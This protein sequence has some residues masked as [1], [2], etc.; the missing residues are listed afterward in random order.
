MTH[1]R[2]SLFQLKLDR[3]PARV[4]LER[5][6]SRSFASLEDDTMGRREESRAEPQCKLLAAL[7]NR[8]EGLAPPVKT[9]IIQIKPGRRDNLQAN[10]A[11]PYG[12]ECR[13][14]NRQ[15]KI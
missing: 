11:D 5:A 10:C 1:D 7:L 4:I 6:P 9:F 14:T 12:L 15:I 13:P 3:L 2:S 8:R